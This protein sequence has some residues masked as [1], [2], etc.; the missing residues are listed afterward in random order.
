MRSRRTPKS[1]TLL[2]NPSERTVTL[3]GN[4]TTTVRVYEAAD[5]R[6]DAAFILAHGAGAGQQSVFI[7]DFAR[8]LSALGVDV[9]TF[10]FPYIE[11]H[12]RIPDRNPVLEACFRAVIDWT[13]SGVPSA[14]R[15]LFIG[16]KSMGG[17]IATQ[18]AA[19]DPSLAI[20]GLVLLG[21]PLH[22][23]GRP[24]ERRDRHL[25]AIG[26][27][28]LFVQGSGD[29]FG[30]PEQLAPAVAAMRPPPTVRVVKDGDHSFKLRRKDAPAQAEVYANIQQDIVSWIRDIVMASAP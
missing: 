17:R 1:A 4:A 28:V 12:R 30:T 15:F 16:G 19:A 8:A 11:Q 13:R 25:P 14:H 9:V 29:A 18:V 27:P 7:V 2:K 3:E 10:N 20:A 24:A 23:P 26:R 6:I 22:P 21:Y 5:P